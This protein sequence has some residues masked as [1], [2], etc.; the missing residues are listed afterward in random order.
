[1]A[2]RSCSR[3]CHGAETGGKTMGSGAKLFRSGSLRA[4]IRAEGSPARI[5][6]RR[7][8]EIALTLPT[9]PRHHASPLG[10]PM[11]LPHAA[12]DNDYLLK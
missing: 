2:P 12:V 3:N 5:A 10:K 6:Q 8:M 9:V 11:R 7:L 1:M 4:A